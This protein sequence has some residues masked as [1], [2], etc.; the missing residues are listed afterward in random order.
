MRL[1]WYLC[2][3]EF[4]I[5]TGCVTGKNVVSADTKYSPEKLQRDF[6]LFRNILQTYHPSLYWYCDSQTLNRRFADAERLLSDSLNEPAFRKILSYVASS[7]RCGHTTVR[8]SKAW[9]RY[10]DTAFTGKLFPLSLKAWPDTFVVIQN[11]HRNDTVLKRG[12]VVT[13]IN[14]LRLQYIADSLFKYLSSDGGNLTHKYQTLSNRG[15]FGSLYSLIFGRSDWYE[16]EYLAEDNR[17]KTVRMAAYDPSKDTALRFAGTGRPPAGVSRKEQRR[18]SLDAMRLLKID[19]ANRTAMMNVAT[20]GKGYG[21]KSFFR[22][23]FKTLHQHRIAHLIIDIRNNGGGIVSNSTALT[24]YLVK[25]PFKIA[26]S[27]YA[28]RKSGPYDRYIRHHFWNKLFITFFTRKK[29]NGR[30]HFSY[31]EKHFFRP[32]RRHHFDGKIYILTGG[33]T[34]S[35]ATLFCSALAGQSNVRIVGEET[36]GS[37]Y[38]NSAWLI[39]DVT[40]PET[41]VRFRLPL[42]RLVMSRTRLKS[43]SGI[44]PDVPV[45]PST[46]AI[47]RN[48]DFKLEKAFELIRN[49]GDGN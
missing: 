36:G 35:A 16:V 38:G 28:V 34:F 21:L 14:G 49:A 5:T 26:D 25:Q 48:A 47:R 30:Y 10:A 1:L 24:R 20:F 9:N 45:L 46:D 2:L 41:G 3:F 8:P 23:S 42:F 39:P 15:S 6:R 12:T 31:Y 11:L 27:L 22:R 19:T 33:N 29:S 37:A 13:K 32:C 40:L 7:I 44:Q 4:V 17:L 43:G 18:Q